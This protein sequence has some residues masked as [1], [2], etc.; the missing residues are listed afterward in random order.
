MERADHVRLA[1]RHPLPWGQG[2]YDSAY[3]AQEHAHFYLSKNP[4]SLAWKMNFIITIN[5]S[6]QTGYMMSEM[7][8]TSPCQRENKKKKKT[9]STAAFPGC[10]W[11]KKCSEKCT[12]SKE[13]CAMA[14]KTSVLTGLIGMSPA[15]RKPDSAVLGQFHPGIHSPGDQKAPAWPVRMLSQIICLR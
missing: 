9:L 14:C 12:K 3:N 13:S 11:K 2:S 10:W 15:R 1:A 7:L 6:E 8:H 5:I 4:E